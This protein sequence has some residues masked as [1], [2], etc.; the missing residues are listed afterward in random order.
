MRVGTPPRADLVWADPAAKHVNDRRFALAIAA[1]LGIALPGARAIGS[2]DELDDHLARAQMPVWVCK[3]AW[4]SAGRDRCWGE[5]AAIAGESRAHIARMLARC[6]A[7]VV[8]PWLDRAGD[9]GACA[10]VDR[11]GRVIALPRH[12]LYVDPG[13]RFASIWVY[14][15][16][17]P[18]YDRVVATV[19]A[20]G[21]ALAHAGY[22]GPFGIDGFTYF[23]DDDRELLHPLCE[24]NARYTFGHV[25]S[26]LAARTGHDMLG[27]GAW[28]RPAAVELITTTPDDPTVAAWL[29]STA[30]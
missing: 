4:T 30:A 3:A 23:V 26:A 9:F 7:V 2:L 22:A 19:E 24:I 11:D 1:E 14:E 25:A 20:V 16:K 12:V 21:R 6:G 17:I 18:I 15:A 10:T 8:E 13:G 5:G 29:I 28:R 27:F